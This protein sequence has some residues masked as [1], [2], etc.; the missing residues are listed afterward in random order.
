[1]QHHPFVLSMLTLGASAA[2]QERPAPPTPTPTPITAALHAEAPPTPG[3]RWSPK[4]A[5]VELH[6]AGAAL[7]GQFALGGDELPVVRC[8]LE[9]SAGAAHFDRIWIDGD[10]DGKV[11]EREQLTAKVSE[12]RGKWWSSADTVVNI[13]VRTAA[14]NTTRPYPIACWFVEDPQ[15][16]DAAPALRWSRRGWHEGTFTVDDKPAFVVVAEAVLDG[17]ID[18]Q[19][20]WSLGRDRD[21]AIG[22]AFPSIDGHCWLDGKAYRVTAVDPN[23]ASITFES[24]DPGFTEAEERARNDDLAPDR[25]AKRAATPLAFGTDLAAALR[26]AMAGGKQVFVDFQTTWC[27]PCHAMDQ[28]VYTAQAVVDAATAVIAVKL[29]GDV[30]RE[31]VKRYAV[32]GYPTMLLLDGD[33]KELKRLAGYQHVTDMVTFFATAK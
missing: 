2:A 22:D 18:R 33:G 19:D 27:G 17:R 15:E 12:T 30:A 23:G 32:T 20:S 31:I 3:P 7:E 10:R 4:G 5:K 28:Y 11:G 16:P 26:D 29:D 9:K 8:R 24:Y 21:A 25:A 1:M 6:A 14:G 13:P